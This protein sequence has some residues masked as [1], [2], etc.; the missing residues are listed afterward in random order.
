MFLQCF[1]L[2]L[3]DIC[4]YF[5]AIFLFFFFFFVFFLALGFGF[6]GFGL[7]GQGSSQT[8]KTNPFGVSQG[9]S[10]PAASR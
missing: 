6:S 2:G 5:Y 8:N 9:F 7:G 10:S 3:N 4:L 1:S